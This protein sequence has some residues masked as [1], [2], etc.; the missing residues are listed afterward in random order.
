MQHYRHP[1]IVASPADRVIEKVLR[2]IA[3]RLDVLHEA[4]RRRDLICDIALRHEAARR[5]YASGSI[6]HGT[7]NAPLGDADCGVVIDRRP[8]LF[9][10]FG[11]DA[12]PG[13]RGPEAFYQL[14][15]AFIEAQVREA[16]YPR[17]E[18]DLTGNRAIKFVFNEPVELDELGPVDPYVDL[19]VA[20]RR[21]EDHKGLW[22]PNRRAAWWDPANPERHTE[23]MTSRDPRSLSVHRT[24]VVRLA[25]RAVKRDG[26]RDGGVQ[27]MCSWNISALSLDL[28]ESRVPLAT[29]LAEFF[30]GASA[31]IGRELTDD[32][33]HVAGP[34][35][36]PDGVTQAMAARR[37]AEMAQVVWAAVGSHS[38]F[39]AER[40]LSALFGTEIDE[41]RASE[42]A[43]LHRHPVNRAL[44]NRDTGAIASALSATVPLKRTASDGD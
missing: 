34:I 10:A 9:R 20:L 12:G 18:L 5:T 28:V 11:P 13:G 6:A 41:V 2:Q 7:H 39:E 15:A 36:L 44:R 19:I 14:F 8:E 27:V 21:D 42:Q 26:A 24:H 16:G 4:K 40:I 23:L 31:A 43:R 37:L 33:A 17:L 25:K 32:P 30:E 35:P 1:P 3:V 29:A 38:E 22:I